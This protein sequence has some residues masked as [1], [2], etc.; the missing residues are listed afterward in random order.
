MYKR[1]VADLNKRL[2]DRELTIELT[3]GAREFVTD[4]GYDPAYG[5]LPL[6]RYLQKNVC[7]LYTS[8]YGH[9]SLYGFQGD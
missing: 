6:K 7:L 4:K 2:A 8:P 1:Q 5:A 3:A 9:A